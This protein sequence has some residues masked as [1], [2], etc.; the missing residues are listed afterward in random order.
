[1][2]FQKKCSVTF[3]AWLIFLADLTSLGA[4]AESV[5]GGKL[6]MECYSNGLLNLSA[7]NFRKH[8]D[9][10][11]PHDT[12]SEIIDVNPL[13]QSTDSSKE[14]SLRTGSKVVKKTCGLLTIKIS[15]G[16]FNANPEGA[17]GGEDN[18]P[19]VSVFYGN[20][21]LVGDYSLGFCDTEMP[22]NQNCKE[23]WAS[24]ITI[25]PTSTL[26]TGK[27]RVEVVR[28]Y[29]EQNDVSLV[30]DSGDKN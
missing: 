27:I 12:T 2:M 25:Y 11:A 1:M 26:S 22:Y 30:E 14:N 19:V 18:Y 13:I 4:K 21:V 8:D 23:K 7:P 9:I 29:T 20:T 24:K 15:G 5:N 3:L 28:E 17:N 16:Y 10:E 6:Y